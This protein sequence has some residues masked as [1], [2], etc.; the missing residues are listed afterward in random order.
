[1]GFSSLIARKNN[2]RGTGVLQLYTKVK[3][4][5]RDYTGTKK[6]TC[7][8]HSR[9]LRIM[10]RVDNYNHGDPLQGEANSIQGLSLSYRTRI[11]RMLLRSVSEHYCG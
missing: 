5:V 9:S 3:G 1:M 7:L 2:S 4:R 10:V 6:A 11:M 8:G